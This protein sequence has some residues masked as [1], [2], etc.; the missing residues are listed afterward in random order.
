MHLFSITN[1]MNKNDFRLI[2]EIVHIFYRH[3][4]SCVPNL[5]TIE[6]HDER[7]FLASEYEKG[8]LSVLYK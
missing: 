5:K 8:L 1:E 3:S 6:V 4:F 7:N 2:E